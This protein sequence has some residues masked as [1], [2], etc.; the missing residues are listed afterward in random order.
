MTW[1]TRPCSI[2]IRMPQLAWQKRQI[3]VVSVM[4]DGAFDRR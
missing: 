3:A 1:T 2:V 4:R